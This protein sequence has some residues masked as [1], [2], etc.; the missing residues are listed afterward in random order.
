MI[1]PTL[2]QTIYGIFLGFA[3]LFLA[4]LPFRPYPLDWLVKS[5]PTAS[6]AVLALFAI[7]GTKGKLLTLGF[8]FSAVGDG[9]LERDPGYF[10]YGLVAFLIAHLFYIA[11]FLK[12][13]AVK[14]PR[15]VI[16]LVVVI[17]GLV[18]G[19]FLVP[20]LG[21]MRVPVMVYLCIILGMGVAAAVG[22][23]NHFVVIIGACFFILSD[24]LI[25]LT[26]F[27]FQFP[28]AVCLL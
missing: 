27:W 2:H 25:L 6:L 11:A 1:R 5:V 22:M 13:P 24:S 12:K 3:L 4:T 19:W 28:P 26:D 15:A 18:L 9:I 17:Y 23:A 14:G 16:A 10:V 8:L 20:H 21:D 7:S